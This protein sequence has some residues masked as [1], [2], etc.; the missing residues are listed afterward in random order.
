MDRRAVNTSRPILDAACGGR[1]FWFDKQHTGAVYM[2]NR[3]LAPTKLSNRSILEVKPDIV[4][5]FRDMPFDDETFALVVFDPPHMCRAGKNSYMAQ[6]YGCLEPD[7]WRDDLR[8]GF[9]ECFRVL[10]P[11]G[12]LIFKWHE[13]HIPLKE[14]LALAPA[15]PLFGNRA[16]GKNLKTHWLCFM[17][18]EDLE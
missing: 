5:D 14:V 9:N 17:K 10:R 3:T 2:D 12:V 13:G 18:M 16:S 7:T 11:Q 15:Q 1:M 8:A 4:A 6:K